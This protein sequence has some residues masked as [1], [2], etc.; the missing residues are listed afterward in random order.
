MDNGPR[1]HRMPREPIQYGSER[2]LQKNRS[3]HDAI[4]RLKK[5][6]HLSTGKRS[7]Q[8]SFNRVKYSNTSWSTY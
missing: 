3:Q 4:V 6:A 8:L 5:N 7:L 2:G 1:K